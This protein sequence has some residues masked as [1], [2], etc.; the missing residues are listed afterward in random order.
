MAHMAKKN[1]C[2]SPVRSTGGAAPKCKACTVTEDW[3]YRLAD[4]PAGVVRSGK[5]TFERDEDCK[6][7]D[8]KWI[9]DDGAEIDRCTVAVT[10][11]I[12][13]AGGGTPPPPEPP[14]PPSPITLEG[15]DCEGNPLPASGLP[16]QITQIVQAP[17]QSL[18]VHLCTDDKDFELAC[19]K[20]KTT[21][22]QIQTAYRTE[23]GGPVVLWRLDTVTGLPWTG[24][25]ATLEACSGSN[26][27][28]DDDDVCVSGQSLRRHTVKKDGKPTGEIYFTD[29]T[30]ALVDVPDGTLIITGRCVNDVACEPTI[31]SAFA[32]D[33]ST[34]LPGRDISVQKPD[35]CAIKVNTSAGSFIVTKKMTGYSVGGFC[36]DVTVTSV[37]ILPGSKCSLDDIVITTTGSVTV[38][39]ETNCCDGTQGDV[40]DEDGSADCDH[41]PDAFDEGGSEECLA[42]YPDTFD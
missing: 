32:S 38:P 40:F 11:L 39:V 12:C 10:D 14:E 15:Q 27:E 29:S 20:D 17:G 42:T 2:P 19:G 5:H 13:T 7:T 34:L 24:D 3:C 36:S 9:G 23:A 6:R 33:L 37:E 18:A 41:G 21:G 31:S 8:E 16:G 1:N 4:D 28:S 26:L 25:P 30:G 35:C 22:N